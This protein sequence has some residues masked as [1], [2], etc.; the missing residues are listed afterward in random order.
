MVFHTDKDS[1]DPANQKM[2]H[3]PSRRILLVRLGSMGDIIHA[4]PALATL[5]EN[6]PAWEIDW[7]VES[8]WRPLLEGNPFLSQIVELDT[9]AWR[10]QPF[11]PRVWQA[12]RRAVRALQERHYDC[13]LDLQGLLKSAAACYWSGAREIVGFEKPWL[14]EPACAVLYTRKVE[15]NAVHVIDA[16]L[17]LAA[18]LGADK[19]VIRFPLPEGDLAAIPSGFPKERLAVLNPGA[20]WRSKCWS[21]ENFGVVADA[22]HK[23]F[24]MQVI[25]NGGPG[26]EQLT[27]QVQA[28]CRNSDPLAFIGNLPG[29]IALLRRSCLLIG[30]DTGPL[31]LA[32]ALG[33]PTVGLYGP[34][35]PQR[36]G[37]YGGHHKFLRPGNAQTTYK[38][39][40]ARGSTMDLIRPEQVLE[41]VRQLLGEQNETISGNQSF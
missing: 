21:P 30:P 4:L 27:R 8:R 1:A 12:L 10:K 40:N 34:T 11:S 33:V 31:H 9:F 24:S 20:G 14:K 22:L 28:A 41:A 18:S 32:A 26:E 2:N 13:A 39:S 15:S 19:P 38:H 35:A 16:N 17:A 37:P 36:N 6:F 23:E 3:N 29:L 5:K 7:L 25:L